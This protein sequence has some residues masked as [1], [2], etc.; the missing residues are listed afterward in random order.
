[1]YIVNHVYV[2]HVY[3]N[4][5]YVNHVYVNHVYVYRHCILLI[6]FIFIVTG[7]F[8]GLNGVATISRLLQIVVS[9][10]NEP[11]KRD[12]IL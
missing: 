5:V 3:V 2:N 1:M 6:R 9:F 11:Y 10:A 7:E 4:H 8:Q 12:D